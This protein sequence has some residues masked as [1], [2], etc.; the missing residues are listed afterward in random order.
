MEESNG[1]K[2]GIVFA[3]LGDRGYMAGNSF[4]DILKS[5]RENNSDGI[6]P[7]INSNEAVLI[8]RNEIPY[9]YIWGTRRVEI[10]D[11]WREDGVFLL[12]RN[13]QDYDLFRYYVDLYREYL[14]K[15]KN[16]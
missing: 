4:E 2:N 7:L 6:F 13:F 14:T 16:L 3:K 15:N 8:D 5:I 10:Y 9:E 1:H 11:D 12:I